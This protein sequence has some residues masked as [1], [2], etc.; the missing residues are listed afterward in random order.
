MKTQIRSFFSMLV[1]AAMLL[2]N[3]QTVAA[4]TPVINMYCV[5]ACVATSFCSWLDFWGQ[6]N[7]QLT[8]LGFCA[9]Q[10]QISQDMSSVDANTIGAKT[11]CEI[12]SMKMWRENSRLFVMTDYANMKTRVTDSMFL[13]ERLHPAPQ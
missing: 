1:V 2:I 9:Q 13:P 7:C 5:E 11:P 12:G 6:I 8:C 3:P 4:Q 10:N